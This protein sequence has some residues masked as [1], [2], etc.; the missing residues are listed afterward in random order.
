MLKEV[1]VSGRLGAVVGGRDSKDAGGGRFTSPLPSLGRGLGAQHP[2]EGGSRDPKVLGELTDRE[3]LHFQFESTFE[4]EDPSWPTEGFALLSCAIETSLRAGYELLSLLL[5]DPSEDRHEQ[6]AHRTLRIKPR[7]SKAHD[8]HTELIEREH[9]LHV[10]HHR[11][12]EAIER[13]HEQHI[14][15]ATVRV[16]QELS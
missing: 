13:P 16:V 7:F 11:A 6:L 8:A 9:G 3:A 15:G 4:V 12:A 1:P 14:E 2:V 5:R 10:A